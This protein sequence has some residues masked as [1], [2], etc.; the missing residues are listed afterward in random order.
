M[1]LPPSLFPELLQ[2]TDFPEDGKIRFN[3]RNFPLVCESWYPIAHLSLHRFVTPCDPP[4]CSIINKCP[5]I[6]IFIRHLK[7]YGDASSIKLEPLQNLSKSSNGIS[8]YLSLDI[9]NDFSHFTLFLCLF[10][11][12]K[13][14]D[15]ERIPASALDWN[16]EPQAPSPNLPSSPNQVNIS[17]HPHM[18]D[19]LAIRFHAPGKPSWM[20]SK[21][22]QSVGISLSGPPTAPS[23]HT[24]SSENTSLKYISLD[25]RTGKAPSPE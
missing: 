20:R 3:L 11:E 6:Y 14:L 25:L 23:L 13:S 12:L 18:M 5:H 21:M 22:V 17:L 16:A 4:F 10:P 9:G 15:L 8:L 7:I 19:T 1:T 24:G 2:Y